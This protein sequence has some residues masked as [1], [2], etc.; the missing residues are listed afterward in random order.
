MEKPQLQPQVETGSISAI[1]WWTGGA[2]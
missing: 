2:P 1:H